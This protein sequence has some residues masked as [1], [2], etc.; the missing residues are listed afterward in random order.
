MTTVDTLRTPNKKRS[1]VIILILELV[2]LVPWAVVSALSGMGFDSGFNWE[3]VFLMLPLWAYP[4]LVLI[5]GII[6]FRVNGGQHQE[7][8]TTIMA[9]PLLIS[10]GWLTLLMVFVQ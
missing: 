6:A 1:L 5:C 3:V 7:R 2:L 9:L 4:A 8:A 10:W